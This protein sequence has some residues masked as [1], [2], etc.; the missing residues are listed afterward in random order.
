MRIYHNIPALNA[1]NNLAKTNGAINKALEKLSSGLR[2]NRAADDAA[3]LAISEKMRGQIS[4]LEQASRNA[5]DGISMIQTA[6]GALNETHSILQRMRELSVQAANDTYTANDRQEIQKEVEQ[7]KDEIDRIASTTEFNTKKLLDG[8]ASALVSSDKLET[9]IIMRD[10][11]RTVDQ[12]GQKA[13]DDGNYKL[14]I[15][16]TPGKGEVQKSDIFKIKHGGDS[17]LNLQIRDASGLEHVTADYLA[18]STAVDAAGSAAAYTIDT[19]HFTT[20]DLSQMYTAAR[21]VGLSDGVNWSSNF[22][23][24]ISYAGSTAVSTIQHSTWAFWGNQD[25]SLSLV[26]TVTANYALQFEVTEVAATGIVYAVKGYVMGLTGDIAAF[27]T[28]LSAEGSDD[29]A[30]TLSANINLAQT[31]GAHTWTNVMVGD[32]NMV[33]I[34]AAV[35]TTAATQGWSQ[36]AFKYNGLYVAEFTVQEKVLDNQEFTFNVRTFDTREADDLAGD[37]L[38]GTVTLIS[39]GVQGTG[40]NYLT[41]AASFTYNVALGNV[42]SL[43]SQLYDIDKFWDA[44]GNFMLTDPKTITLQQGDGKSTSLTL[45]STDTIMDVR[46]KLN[47]AIRDGL[48]QGDIVE[49]YEDASNFVSYVTNAATSG[50]ETVEGTFVIRSA[51]AGSAGEIKFIGDEQFINALSLSTIT[52]ATENKYTVDVTDAHDA[53]KVIAND[54]NISGNKL[55]GIVHKNV[56]VIFDPSAGITTTYDSTNKEFDLAASSSAYTTYVHLADNTAVLQIGA[57]EKQDMGMGIGRMDSLALGVDNILVTDRESA[58]RSI[59]VLDNAISR[60]S[61]QRSSLGAVQNRLEHTINN[62]TV[63]NENLTASESRIRD[64]DMAKEMMEFSK[65]NI[66]S[67]AGTAMLAQANQRPQMVLQLLG[68]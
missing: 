21:V 57:N 41:G 33:T 2:I 19:R 28:T 46:D 7:L 10:G 49:T 5:Q 61:G 18:Y 35:Q 53:T 32:K 38:T 55:I 27:N 65:W 26:S 56:D 37:S 6:E 1:Y 43:D 31:Q 8:S 45:Y 62:L 48:G 44:N 4:G 13:A 42:A 67:Q 54:V 63:A 68:G 17:V 22:T 3:G 66:L 20:G 50:S 51:I 60:V 16:A 59:T 40:Y 58:G 34:A 11:L 64:V 47:N 9:K 14:E 25:V 15:T 29:A 52:D 30:W 24:S 23:A 39:N 12:F 36:V